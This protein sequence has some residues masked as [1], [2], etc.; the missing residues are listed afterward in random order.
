MIFIVLGHV[1]QFIKDL[2]LSLNYE[3]KEDYIN[4]LVKETFTRQLYLKRSKME[5]EGKNE[6]EIHLAWGPRADLEYDK[7]VVLESVSKIMHKS[8]LNF[9]TQYSEAHGNAEETL[10]ID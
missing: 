6:P 8:P 2:P 4:K 9:A 7:K 3:E 1:I 5:I 10:M